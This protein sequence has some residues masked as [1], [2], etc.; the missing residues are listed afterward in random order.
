MALNLPIR[1]CL[2]GCGESFFPKRL[3]HRFYSPACRYRYYSAQRKAPEGLPA[4]WE[5][6]MTTEGWY[7]DTSRPSE[8]SHYFCG[9]GVALCGRFCLPDG[10]KLPL[11]QNLFDK[12]NCPECKER[13]LKG[14]AKLAPPARLERAT[15]GLGSYPADDTTD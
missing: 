7:K 5:G 6:N 10:F 13:F 2:C 1:I 8:P 4:L 11:H 12:E 15:H 3:L 14:E 9:S